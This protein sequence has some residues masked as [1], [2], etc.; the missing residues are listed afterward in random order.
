MFTKE[1][2]EECMKGGMSEEKMKMM[3]KMMEQF[4]AKVKT[5]GEGKKETCGEKKSDKSESRPDMEKVFDLCSQMMEQFST[6]MKED[7]DKDQTCCEK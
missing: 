6:L 4:S 7:D 1:K 5:E 3:L 2:I